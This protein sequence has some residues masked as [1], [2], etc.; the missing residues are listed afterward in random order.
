MKKF[1]TIAITHKN[2]E[3]D[4]IGKF[5]LEDAEE[6]QRLTH[7]KESCDLEELMY[8]STCNRVEF[9]FISEET[10]SQE[11][12]VKFLSAF[13]PKWS[14]KQVN[15]VIKF[16][17]IYEDIK[18]VDHIFSVASSLDSLVI[19]E[20]EIITQV[21]N[22]F[23]K[24][25]KYGLTGNMLRI[26]IQKTIETA[27]AVYTHTEI[28]RKPVSIVS[29]AYRK[30]KSLNVDLKSRFLI[31]GSGQ[32]NTVMCKFLKKHGFE[33]FSVFNRTLTNAEVLSG[34][35]GGQAFTL[36]KLKTYD[37]GFDVIITCTASSEPIINKEIYDTLLN[38]DNATKTI[39]DMAI[40]SD[41]A[42]E[43]IE[44]HNV[45]YISITE[46]KELAS[47]NLKQRKKEVSKCHELI[48]A[49]KQEFKEVYQIRKIE[50]AMQGV[51][52]K[53]KEI[54]ESATSEV[55]V[56]ELEDLD[57]DSREILEKVLNYMEKKYISVPMKMAREILI[58]NKGKKPHA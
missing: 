13:N 50:L 48:E 21:R 7:L 41:I 17:D 55:F 24:A 39:I 56:N 18:A 1:K 34:E 19:G 20:R 29:L 40:P 23:D 28:A 36:D 11:F 45:K 58:D 57:Q 51:P 46:L 4:E 14:D 32:T 6:G 25:E 54:R 53:I 10:L 30:L 9:L 37:K 22:S 2:V 52:K 47:D 15:E 27:K 44:E 26:L 5:H 38:G 16:V 49:K 43:I 42:S 33:N 3:L 12:L 35:I 31:I 8:L